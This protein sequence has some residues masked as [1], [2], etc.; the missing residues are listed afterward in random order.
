MFFILVLLFLVSGCAAKSQLISAS[1]SGNVEKIKNLLAE[2][3]NVNESD[4]NGWTPLM[5]AVW[6]NNINAA[7]YLIESGAD[8][9]AMDK[10]KDK[11][12]LLIASNYSMI[13]MIKMLIEKGANME[14]TDYYGDTPLVYAAIYAM[15]IDAVKLLIQKGA[16]TNTK[17]NNSEYLLSRIFNLKRIKGKEDVGLPFFA[18]RSKTMDIIINELLN[19]GN[20]I[21][22]KPSHDKARIIFFNEAGFWEYADYGLNGRCISK[23]QRFNYLDV[24][25][26]ICEFY[27]AKVSKAELAKQ[28]ALL[29]LVDARLSGQNLTASDYVNFKLGEDDSKPKI[30]LKVKAGQTYY[31]KI[32]KN[33]WLLVDE[34]SG[35][36]KI[37]AM[38]S[39]IKKSAE[40]K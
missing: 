7:K 30:S 12:A 6:K 29:L 2:G 18:K 37:N 34:L 28:L 13:E 17:N 5:Y 14:S 16:D 27:H 19:A 22:Y 32:S 35:K 39:E 9:N 33:E 3:A 4:S 21:L 11:N 38:L 36:D 20:S 15:N 8:I 10:H 40:S 23:E 25:P 1:S 24:E 26:G 31:I